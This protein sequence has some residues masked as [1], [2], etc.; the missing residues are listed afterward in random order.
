MPA[1]GGAGGR[2]GRA[3]AREEP[4]SSKGLGF[5]LCQRRAELEGVEAAL[6]RVRNLSHQRG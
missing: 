2:G 1:Q 3:D 5:M 6:T 4:L